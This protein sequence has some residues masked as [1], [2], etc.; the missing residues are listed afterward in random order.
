MKFYS[1]YPI[2]NKVQYF[3]KIKDYFI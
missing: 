3:G 2:F 1:I